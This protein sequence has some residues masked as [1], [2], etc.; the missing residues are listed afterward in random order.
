MLEK[1]IWIFQWNI[2]SNHMIN[3]TPFGAILNMLNTMAKS[4][5]TCQYK[6]E[7]SQ[8]YFLSFLFADIW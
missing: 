1:V 4:C 2:E 7:I 8:A 3:L 5:L 6:V